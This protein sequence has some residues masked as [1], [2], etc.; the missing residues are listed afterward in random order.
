MTDPGC[1]RSLE[2]AQELIRTL[3]LPS[4]CSRRLNPLVQDKFALLDRALQGDPGDPST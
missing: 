3:N 2:G 1:L 4:D